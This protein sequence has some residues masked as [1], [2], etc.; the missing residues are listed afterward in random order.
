MQGVLGF[1][2]H[3]PILVDRLLGYA[4]RL[5]DPSERTETIGEARICRRLVIE[6]GPEDGRIIYLRRAGQL[7]GRWDP[8]VPEARESRLYIESSIV[9]RTVSRRAM[10]WR[11]ATASISGAM[12]RLN[13]LESHPL[14][15]SGRMMI[16]P[17]DRI[18][19]GTSTCMSVLT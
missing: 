14:T 7:I 9:D 12:F 15:V 13:G 1:S 3:R 2:D 17:G 5:D 10:T 6:G 16:E 4:N 18:W 19:L 11:G 8:A